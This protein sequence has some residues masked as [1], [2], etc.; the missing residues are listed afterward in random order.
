M[1]YI[2]P[3]AKD[4]VSRADSI[5]DRIDLAVIQG[6]SAYNSAAPAALHRETDS[7]RRLNVYLPVAGNSKM[8]TLSVRVLAPVRQAGAYFLPGVKISQGS[9][10]FD[11]SNSNHLKVILIEAKW[12]VAWPPAQKRSMA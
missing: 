10:E 12:N 6:L 5:Q 9:T 8:G 3:I 7:A 2:L 1:G 11:M 4:H